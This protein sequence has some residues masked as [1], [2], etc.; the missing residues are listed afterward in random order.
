MQSKEKA[1]FEWK[2]IKYIRLTHFF[3]L[4]SFFQLRLPPYTNKMVMSERLKYAIRHCRTIDMD[5]Y[6]LQWWRKKEVHMNVSRLYSM[7]GRV[8]LVK[9]CSEIELETKKRK[10]L[11]I[12]P[13]LSVHQHV[14]E[15]HT[16]LINKVVLCRRGERLFCIH[17]HSRLTRKPE[18]SREAPLNVQ[19]SLLSP[20]LS[21]LL[22]WPSSWGRPARGLVSRLGPGDSG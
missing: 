3:F 11:T 13:H 8:I 4:F 21:S 15:V 1:L 22:R 19:L 20:L 18:L 2:S 7:L 10:C 14:L 6:M 17:L 16:L 9:N 5:N 12:L